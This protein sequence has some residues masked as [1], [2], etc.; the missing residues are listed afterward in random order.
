VQSAADTADA[1]PYVTELG[2]DLPPLLQQLVQIVVHVVELL[3]ELGLDLPQARQHA[4]GGAPCSGLHEPEVV[5]VALVPDHQRML[6][7]R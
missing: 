7:A 2:D 1:V 3:D 4:A 5:R 6:V